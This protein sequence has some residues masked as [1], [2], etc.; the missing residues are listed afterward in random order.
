MKKKHECQT[1]LSGDK[2]T[3]YCPV[4][5]YCVEIR[6][7]VDWTAATFDEHGKLVTPPDSFGE[8]KVID[9]G[10]PGVSHSA[11]FNPSGLPIRVKL[12]TAEVKETLRPKNIFSNN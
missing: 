6:E 2:L 9:Q 5:G 4:C 1:T 12:V 8:M 10:L 7:R 3:H 11:S